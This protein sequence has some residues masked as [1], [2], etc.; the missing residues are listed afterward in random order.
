[1]KKLI[2]ILALVMLCSFTFANQE[3]REK[4]ETIITLDHTDYV[5]TFQFGENSPIKSLAVE[6]SGS[7]LIGKTETGQ[8]E[9]K[10]TDKKD[11]FSLKDFGATIDF[12]RNESGA[13]TGAVLSVNGSTFEG[14]KK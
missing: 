12:K 9:L 5:G 8:S 14:T 1:M 6:A 4:A 2:S 3:T 10:A 13:V 7:G 11:S